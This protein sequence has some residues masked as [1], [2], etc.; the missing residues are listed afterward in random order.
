MS[1]N[2]KNHNIIVVAPTFYAD[3]TDLRYD[4]GLTFCR[5]AAAL[6]I[7]VI[8]VDASS[9]DGA[10]VRQAL[11]AAGNGHV[12]VVEQTAQ[13][14][15]GA[16][17]RQALQLA[18]EATADADDDAILCFQEPE[19]I[20]M[21]NHWQ[22]VAAYMRKENIDI[23]N[24]RRE[25]SLFQSTYPTEQYHSESFVNFYLDALA[26]AAAPAC[27]LPSIDWT[28]GPIALRRTWAPHWQA[29]KGDL[30]DAQMVPMIRSH[31]QHGATVGSCTV[32]FCLPA[33]MK[34]QEEGRVMWCEKRLAQ[35]NLLIPI[36]A[37]EFAGKANDKIKDEKQG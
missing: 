26:A 2:D 11:T 13:G 21:L 33:A 12:Q 31:V 28:M 16:A 23:C 9:P 25:A 17:L 30:W 34:A 4:L 32:P 36:L 8:L 7:R 6:R 29:Y 15:K 24:P 14:R 37:K 35:I 27:S 19:K 3:T 18:Y 10:L 20:D 22:T 5:Q 1:S